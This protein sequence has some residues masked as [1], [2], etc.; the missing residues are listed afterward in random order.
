MFPRTRTVCANRCADARNVANEHGDV[1]RRLTMVTLTP[2]HS[3][4][5]CFIAA[6]CCCCQR[7]YYGATCCCALVAFLVADASQMSCLLSFLLL[8]SLARSPLS[9]SLAP[10]QFNY[11]KDFS[12]YFS[13]QKWQKVAPGIR[14]MN[15]YKGAVCLHYEFNIFRAHETMVLRTRTSQHRT[16]RW[17]EQIINGILLHELHAF[18]LRKK[19]SIFN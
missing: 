15:I 8:L 4:D 19:K 6:V 18:K 11:S 10:L 9:L 7:Y 16:E 14:Y 13:Q 1:V 5:P 3:I 17:H 2:G 12:Y